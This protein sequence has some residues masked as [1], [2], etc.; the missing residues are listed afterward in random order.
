MILQARI[1]WESVAVEHACVMG[2]NEQFVQM[3]KP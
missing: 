1:V 2:M 3:S